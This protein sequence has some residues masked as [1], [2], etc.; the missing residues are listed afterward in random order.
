V[1]V[2][3]SN[4]SPFFGKADSDGPSNSLGGTDDDGIVT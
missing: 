1:N 4:V 2:P 3:E